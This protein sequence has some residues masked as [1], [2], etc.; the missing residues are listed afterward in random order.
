MSIEYGVPVRFILLAIFA[1]LEY[2][3]LLNGFTGNLKE[4]VRRGGFSF[5]KYW[6]SSC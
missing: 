5:R 2:F 4:T 6:R 3:R 1:P